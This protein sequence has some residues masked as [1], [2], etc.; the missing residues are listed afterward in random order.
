LLI[1]VIVRFGNI[2]GTLIPFE[3][4]VEKHSGTKLTVTVPLGDVCMGKY[5][6]IDREVSLF[7]LQCFIETNSHLR[8]VADTMGQN[9]AELEIYLH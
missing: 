5:S 4:P 3:E 9:I 6:F 2:P 8:Y 7:G 1:S